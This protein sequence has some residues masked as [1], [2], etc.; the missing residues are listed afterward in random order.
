LK[1]TV[2]V[3]TDAHVLQTF[4]TQF[5][6]GEVPG[7]TT[8]GPTL[9][10]AGLEEHPDMLGPYLFPQLQILYTTWVLGNSLPRN[11]VEDQNWRGPGLGNS[12]T[13]NKIHK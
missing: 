2:P 7:K 13:A 12:R 3:I 1:H 5:G 10:G 6:Y 4:F 8:L 11:N 9:A